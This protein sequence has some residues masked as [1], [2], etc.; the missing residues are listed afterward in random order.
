MS[1]NFG[2]NLNY[3]LVKNITNKD[4]VYSENRNLPHLISCGSILTEANANSIVWG[5]GFAWHHDRNDRIPLSNIYG[6]R[7]ELSKE[8]FDKDN[9]A[10]GDPALLLRKF[11]NPTIEKKH[12]YGIIPHWKDIENIYRMNLKDVLII[13]PLQSFQEV[14]QQVLSCENI[15]SSSLHGL[16]IAD[17][18]EVPNSWMELGTDIGGDGF[19]FQDYYTTTNQGICESVKGVIFDSC[20]IHP[21]KYDLDVLLK[22]FPF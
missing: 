22:S 7:G 21:Y 6:V 19:K 10:V 14:V 8:R 17:L 4:V 18:Y 11:F 5:A 1:N 15:L 2:D 3:F 16:I 13:N 9:I 12:K 20:E